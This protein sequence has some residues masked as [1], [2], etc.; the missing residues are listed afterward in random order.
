MREA[1][2]N[3]KF[4]KKAL[5]AVGIVACS[6]LGITACS[7]AETSTATG[8]PIVVASVNAL[9]GAATFSEASQAAK[10]VFDEFNANGGLDGRP[11][12]YEILDDKGDPA[13]ASAAARDAVGKN[14]V[15]LV[16][17]ASLLDCEVNSSYYEQEGIVAVQG[18]GVDPF[19]FSTPNISAVN[20]GPYM[21]TQLTLTYGSETL[22]LKKICGLLQIAGSTRPAY[23]AAI[24]AWTAATGESFA[25]L[26]DTV[27]YGAPDYTPYVVKAKEAGCDGI[28]SNGVEPDALG[29]LKAAE[30]QGMND[31]TFLFL[32]SAYSE[33]FA[34]AA[35]FVGKGVYVPAEFAPYTVDGITA[36]DEW[37]ALMEKHNVPLTSFGQGGYLAATHFLETL[38]TMEGDITRENVTAAFKAQTVPSENPMTG[39][40]FLFGAGESHGS[41]TAGWPITIKPGSNAWTSAQGDWMKVS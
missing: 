24:D 11:I 8:E 26:D 20:A 19:C 36:N 34:Q 6:L 23:Q 4:Q 3:M 14:A 35:S 17:S 22:G 2:I 27:P 5:A 33:Q 12:Q 28:Y 21:D 39:T 40:P 31:M 41:N 29:V 18:T 38:K 7:Q 37:K 15:A 9:S 16:G 32:T 13:S 25:M 1:S 10:A 30:A